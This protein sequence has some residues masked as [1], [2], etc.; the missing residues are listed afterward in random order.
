MKHLLAFSL[1]FLSFTLPA[2]DTVNARKVINELTSKSLSGRGYVNK[3][4][5]NAATYLN[6]QYV[7]RLFL[8]VL[9]VLIM[10]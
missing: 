9:W 10:K 2:Q 1:F 7:Q 3:G 8:L 5:E 6:N 4:V